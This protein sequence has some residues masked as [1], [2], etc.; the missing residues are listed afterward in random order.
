MD[1][2][3]PFNGRITFSPCDGTPNERATIRDR[4]HSAGW[5]VINALYALE[6]FWPAIEKQYAHTIPISPT[7]YKPGSREFYIKALTKV[8]DR[9]TDPSRPIPFQFNS[10]PPPGHP[11]ARAYV[12]CHIGWTIHIVETPYFL[13]PVFTQKEAIYHELG[14]L[15]AGICD[16]EGETTDNIDVWDHMIG[17]LNRDFRTLLAK[18]KP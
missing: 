15:I 3:A 17:T 10:S 6:N 18:S 9:L 11:T 2:G 13:S 4:T 1:I 8:R 5:S 16:D 14:R 12:I 7:L